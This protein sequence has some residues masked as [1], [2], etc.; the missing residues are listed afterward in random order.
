MNCNEA[1]DRLFADRDGAPE[2]TPR[3]ALDAHVAQCAAC[4]RISDDL[5][6]ALTTW[7]D[8]AARTPVP[9]VEREWHAVRRI[10]RGGVEAGTTVKL[11]PRRRNFIPWLAVPV[12]AA[13]AI[14]GA[15]YVASTG[16]TPSV[17]SPSPSVTTHVARADSVEVPGNASTMVYV[18]DKS[19]WLVVWA[20]DNQI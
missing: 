20:N 2:T 6:A 18:D 16:S 12:G 10:I 3:A 14:A 1:Q 17:P 15:L 4:R 11:A 8:T 9:D 19:G 5:T 7:R 13:A